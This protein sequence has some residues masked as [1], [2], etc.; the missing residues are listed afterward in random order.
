MNIFINN[1]HFRP[2]SLF[3]LTFVLPCQGRIS[4]LIE[5][6]LIRLHKLMKWVNI[7]EIITNEV[8]PKVDFCEEESMFLDLKAWMVGG[9]QTILMSVSS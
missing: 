4:H 9:L 3:S 2:Q 5:Y 8:Q 1:V 6:I 7:T